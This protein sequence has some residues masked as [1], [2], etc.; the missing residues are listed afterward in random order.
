[1]IV[2]YHKPQTVSETI[3]LLNRETINTVPLGGG[4][5]LSHYAGEAI[6]VVDLILLNL[7]F[8]KQAG[9][10]LEIGATTTLQSLIDN[11]FIDSEIKR[12]CELEVNYNLRQIA[13]IG[14]CIASK[15]KNSPLIAVLLAM[16]PV[17]VIQPDHK[18][19]KMEEWLSFSGKSGSYIDTVIIEGKVKVHFEMINRTP[20]SRPEILVCGCKWESGRV[21]FSTYTKDS[22]TPSIIFDGI[23]SNES[24]IEFL[25]N[26]YSQSLSLDSNLYLQNTIPTLL[27]RVLDYVQ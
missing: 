1:M 13:T 21:R 8:I 27:S 2:E 6:A 18:K 10:A 22:P 12:A 23:E 7:D 14:G 24:L 25:I 16:D 15:S 11:K 20:K 5:V 3:K 4:T 17:L 26:A 19:M 9:G